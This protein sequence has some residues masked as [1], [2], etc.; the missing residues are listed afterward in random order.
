MKMMPMILIQTMCNK[1]GGK[2]LSGELLLAFRTV[3][4]TGV[5]A[6]AGGVLQNQSCC[7]DSAVAVSNNV[8]NS[9]SPWIAPDFLQV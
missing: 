5:A 3:G 1:P 2:A 4:N 8:H 7:K 6:E 9:A